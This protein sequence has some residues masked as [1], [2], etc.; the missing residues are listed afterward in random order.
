MGRGYH[1][2]FE[3]K[4]SQVVNVLVMWSNVESALKISFVEKMF[5]INHKSKGLV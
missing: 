3:K 1:V 5:L 2:M 4:K